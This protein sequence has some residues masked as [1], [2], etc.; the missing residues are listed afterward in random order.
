M[1][2]QKKEIGKRSLT[3]DTSACVGIRSTQ[4]LKG[5]VR[6]ISLIA[7]GLLDVRADLGSIVK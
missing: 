4:P 1:H 3:D 6:E 5:D 7:K 2:R